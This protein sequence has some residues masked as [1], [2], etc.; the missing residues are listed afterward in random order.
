[1]SAILYNREFDLDSRG[2]EQVPAAHLVHE[3]DRLIRCEHH[4]ARLRALG[5]PISPLSRVTKRSPQTTDNEPI[6][7]EFLASTNSDSK[8]AKVRFMTR[9][10]QRSLQ[11]DADHGEVDERG[12]GSGVALEVAC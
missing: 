7:D 4:G 5:P 8:S 1:M 6:A 12:N 11:H 10:L 2:S 9:S 3:V